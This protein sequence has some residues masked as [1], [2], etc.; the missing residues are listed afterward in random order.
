MVLQAFRPR[1][2]RPAAQLLEHGPPDQVAAPQVGQPRQP[3]CFRRERADEA[4]RGVRD[5]AVGHVRARPHRGEQPGDQVGRASHTG[6]EHQQQV[7]FGLGQEPVVRVAGAAGDRVVEHVVG[8]RPGRLRGAVLADEDPR[9]NRRPAREV[10]DERG[11]PGVADPPDDEHVEVV[12]ARRGPRRER[13][14]GRGEDPAVRPPGGFRALHEQ[15]CRE[16]PVRAGVAAEGGLAEEPRVPARGVHGQRPIGGHDD[17]RRL[18]ERAL[19]PGRRR[20]P[21]REVRGQL[22]Q[23]PGRRAHVQLFLD[24]AVR[25]GADRPLQLAVAQHR[26]GGRADD[27]FPGHEQVL[28]G[29]ERREITARFGDD[30]AAV[31]GRLQHPHPLQGPGRLAVQV[32]QHPA[33]GQ[34]LVL[35]PAH[36]EV[37][38]RLDHRL[39][40]RCQQPDREAVQVAGGP[41]QERGPPVLGGAEVGDVDV[42][43]RVRV[44][45]PPVPQRGV[46]ELE[47]ADVVA[48]PH[49][50][51]G[52]VGVDVHRA[53]ELGQQAR[54]WCR[55]SACRGAR[56]RTRSCG[57][58]GPAA[59]AAARAAPRGT[60]A[61]RRRRPCRRPRR[62]AA[63][64]ASRPVRRPGAPR[65]RRP[66]KALP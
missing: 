59:A 46:A 44:A 40:R 8:L 10:I 18:A 53:A 27:G 50:L 64:R 19:R 29:G 42:A 65:R 13:Q 37:R 15:P 48:A 14:R 36:Q 1:V 56:R 23:R 60:R 3:P 55:R 9:R 47:P 4:P 20:V 26:R 7:G 54:R 5:R 17:R 25:L 52:G 38:S 51:V 32:Q 58:A 41:G 24:E 28:P 34:V 6:V 66:R 30:D 62:A 45:T 16:P 2:F 35:R 12:R 33:A 63:R 39:V 49:Q 61:G 11:D 21:L 31:A 43:R 22:Q 57:A